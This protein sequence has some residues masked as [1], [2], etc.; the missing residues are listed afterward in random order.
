MCA[1]IHQ[2]FYNIFQYIYIYLL[3]RG[4]IVS[5]Q[6]ALF[7]DVSWGLEQGA[8]FTDC[9]YT[10]AQWSQCQRA[11]VQGGGLWETARTRQICQ[12]SI[13][14]Q[15]FCILS[16]SVLFAYVCH[17]WPQHSALTGNSRGRNSW[18][19]THFAVQPDFEVNDGKVMSRGWVPASKSSRIRLQLRC[20]LQWF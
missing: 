13:E 15:P 7:P 11:G 2:P 1:N 18:T 10:A 6:H 19:M 12:D 14:L 16:I 9:P 5:M 20:W 4:H 8:Q 3:L 17:I